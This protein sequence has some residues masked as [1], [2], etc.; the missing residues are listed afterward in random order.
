MKNERKEFK[1][2]FFLLKKNV[3]ARKILPEVLP[4]SVDGL[5]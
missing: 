1:S 4:P 3:T 5:I 2:V